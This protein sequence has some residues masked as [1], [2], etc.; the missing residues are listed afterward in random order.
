VAGDEHGA[1]RVGSWV[2]QGGGERGVQQEQVG[3][4]EFA[5]G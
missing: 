3:G 5:Q 2:A 4:G 1:D